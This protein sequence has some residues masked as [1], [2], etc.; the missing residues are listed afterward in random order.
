MIQNEYQ[1]TRKLFISWGLENALK[2]SQLVFS[3]I[4]FVLALLML[5]LEGASDSSLIINILVVFCI[6]RAFLRWYVVS[7]GQYNRL[8]KNHNGADWT[9]VISF[10]ENEIVIDEGAFSFKYQYM[11]IINIKEKGNKVWLTARNKTV[12][13]LYKDCF[14]NGTWESCKAHVEKR[15]L[16][17]A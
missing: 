8:A 1:I 14:K 4:Y 17:K 11:D 6:Y 7:N 5:L 12:I 2:G 10:G 3:I 13:R 16:N 15:A 9:R